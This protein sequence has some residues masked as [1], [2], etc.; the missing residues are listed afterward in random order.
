MRIIIDDAGMPIEFWDEAVEYDS[1]VRNRLPI[2]P[3][4]NGQLRTPI[5]AYTGVRPHVRHIRPWGCKAFG[6]VNP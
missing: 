3:V 6:Y 5:E 1:Y 2:G 4:V